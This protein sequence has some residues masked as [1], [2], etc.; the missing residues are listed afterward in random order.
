MLTV[1]F[2]KLMLLKKH[3]RKHGYLKKPALVCFSLLLLHLYGC[4]LSTVSSLYTLVQF[5]IHPAS[6]HWEISFNAAYPSSL[7]ISAQQLDENCVYTHAV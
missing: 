6:R 2:G 7:R 5:Y 1:L 3:A 4:P